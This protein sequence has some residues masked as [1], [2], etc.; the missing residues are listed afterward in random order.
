M[1]P[2]ESQLP[3]K[4]PLTSTKNPYPEVKD[5][6]SELK[7]QQPQPK[8]IYP[9]VPVYLTPDVLLE[10]SKLKEILKNVEKSNKQSIHHIESK[11]I[12]VHEK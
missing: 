10:I 7:T 1:K 12:E 5:Y 8:N 2:Q 6:L 11:L 4:S 3:R 9:K